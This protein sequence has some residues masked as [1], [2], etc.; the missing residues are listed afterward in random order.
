MKSKMIHK[1][2]KIMVTRVQKKVQ[3][4]YSILTILIVFITVSSCKENETVSPSFNC[5]LIELVYP[6]EN[7]KNRKRLFEYDLNNKLSKISILENQIIK[8]YEIIKRKENKLIS[9][10]Y[11]SNISNIPNDLFI[12]TKSENYELNAKGQIIKKDNDIEYTYTNEGF[13]KSS[14]FKTGGN[15]KLEFYT[16][17]SNNII[18]KLTEYYTND[19]LWLTTITK[20]E[21]S[22]QLND[23]PYN[24]LFYDAN[25]S[26]LFLEGYYGKNS[27]NKLIKVIEE[28]KYVNSP[29]NNNASQVNLIYKYDLSNNANLISYDSKAVLEVKLKCD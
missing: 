20:F 26:W 12:L 29:N 9:E 14:N 19:K 6:E 13:L 24:F 7:T 3:R 22:N 18:E 21:Y 16:I 25:V 28:S 11:F 1:R 27:K 17:Q 2:N 5:K 10:K 4:I 15:K 8:S 23:N